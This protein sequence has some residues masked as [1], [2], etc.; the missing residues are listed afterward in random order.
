MAPELIM[1]KPAGK[2]MALNVSGLLLFSVAVAVTPL[3]VSP[4]ASVCVAGGV[5][6]GSTLLS[7]SQVNV[8]LPLVVPLL[9]ETVTLY[10]LLVLSPLAIVPVIRPVLLLMLRPEGRSVAL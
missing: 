9:A 3:T 7:T 2:P 5:T 6:T 4:S 10:G 8:A 1:V